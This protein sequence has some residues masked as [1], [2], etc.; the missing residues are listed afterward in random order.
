MMSDL[1]ARD[2][3]DIYTIA[4]VDR[5]VSRK[6]FVLHAMATIDKATLQDIHEYTGI[7]N[8]S[9]GRIITQ[10]RHEDGIRII[11]VRTQSTDKQRLP[12]GKSG[13]Y[14]IESW[15]KFDGETFL[16]TFIDAAKNF[17]SISRIVKPKI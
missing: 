1:F 12:I 17:V 10:L 8:S 2:L 5:L 3:A 15:G 9:L 6:L 14:E 16:K 11:Y 7:P 4:S 13:H